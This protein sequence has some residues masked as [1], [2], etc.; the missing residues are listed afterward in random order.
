MLKI[1]RVLKDA[2]DA[3]ILGDADTCQDFKRCRC[4]QR[5]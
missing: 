5:F 1:A 4:L 2:A 3:R